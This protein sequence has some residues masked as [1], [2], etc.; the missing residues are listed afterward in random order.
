[1]NSGKVI[2]RGN[3][4]GYSSVD[5]I[6]YGDSYLRCLWASNMDIASFFLCS[7]IN[8]KLF[9]K[10]FAPLFVLSNRVTRV[11]GA[12]APHGKGSRA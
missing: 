4:D 12:A 6:C 10:L 3:L 11:M 2:P 5:W 9:T 7:D 1:V 8:A